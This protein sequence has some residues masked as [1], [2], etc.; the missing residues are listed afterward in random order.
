M[1]M[2]ALLRAHASRYCSEMRRVIREEPKCY[3]TESVQQ[4]ACS[5]LLSAASACD[6]YSAL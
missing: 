6:S 3:L 1:R 5:D 4:S 2:Q